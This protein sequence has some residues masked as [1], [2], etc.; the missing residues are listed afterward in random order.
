[1]IPGWKVRLRLSRGGFMLHP[2]S[3]SLG[4]ITIKDDEEKNQDGLLKYFILDDMLNKELGSNTM[5]VVK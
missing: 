4:C 3:M 5:T 1:M 2:G